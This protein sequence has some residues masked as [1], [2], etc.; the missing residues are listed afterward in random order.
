MVKEKKKKLKCAHD[1]AFFFKHALFISAIFC[2]KSRLLRMAPSMAAWTTKMRPFLRANAATASST[3][4]LVMASKT[5]MTLYFRRSIQ[6]SP[7]VNCAVSIILL[8]ANEKVKEVGDLEYR[9]FQRKGEKK[10]ES[11]KKKK[12][13]SL[14]VS[15]PV[16][17]CISKKT[18][19][20][21]EACALV[22][23][24]PIHRNS[25]LGPCPHA[26]L[27]PLFSVFSPRGH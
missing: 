21:V 16:P 23:N 18:K 14:C 27:R 24:S 25:A 3:E 12:T 9:E 20:P 1:A 15:S 19:T 2:T 7:E 22:G 5:L 11:K 26:H 4:L 10:N 8:P 6:I 17:H 13:V